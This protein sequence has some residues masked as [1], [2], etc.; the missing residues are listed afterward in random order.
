MR[1]MEM[2]G[3]Y[4]KKAGKATLD[5]VGIDDSSSRLLHR[6]KD[7]I[8]IPAFS[9]LEM[10]PLAPDWNTFLAVLGGWNAERG[11]QSLYFGGT[12]ENPF[13]VQM[14]TQALHS[15]YTGGTEGFLNAIRPEGIKRLENSLQREARRQ[16]D[17]FAIDS[18][19]SWDELKHA[20]DVLGN[21][22]LKIEDSPAMELFRTRHVLRGQHAQLHTR[23]YDMQF[24]SG[25][26]VAPDHADLELTVP[27]IIEQTALL[28]DPPKAD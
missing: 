22:Q 16:G 7:I 19:Y 9:D 12:D 2:K 13:L 23:N 8:Y 6:E 20:A 26:V 5:F 4:P 3:N 11:K 18:G 25:T 10:F 21:M 14:N 24:V 17:I 27:Y 28:Y 15:F 1:L